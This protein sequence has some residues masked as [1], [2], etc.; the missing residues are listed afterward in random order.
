[1]TNKI[2]ILLFS[3]VLVLVVQLPATDRRRRTNHTFTVGLIDLYRT[4]GHIPKV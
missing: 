4:W 2:F 3:L 1:M